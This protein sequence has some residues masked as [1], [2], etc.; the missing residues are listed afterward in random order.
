MSIKNTM[1]IIN[2]LLCLSVIANIVCFLL[3][4]NASEN[5]EKAMLDKEICIALGD[6]LREGSKELTNNARMYAASGDKKYENNYHSILNERTGKIPRFAHRS[7]FP[8]EKYALLDLLNRYGISKDEK[9]LISRAQHLSDAVVPIEIEAF[10]AVKGVFKDRNGEYT[11]KKMPDREK[12]IELVFGQ[13][14]EELIQPI[15]RYMASFDKELHRRLDNVVQQAQE[16]QQLYRMIFL[17]STVLMILIIFFS[18]YYT[19]HTII[20]PLRHT[21]DFAAQIA[22]GQFE[23]RITVKSRNEIGQLVTALNT[24]ADQITKFIAEVRMESESAKEHSQNAKKALEQ[25]ETATSEAQTRTR[26]MLGV[27][28]RLDHAGDVISSATSQLSS[29]LD[30]SDHGA[31]ETAERLSLAAE[32]IND[33]NVTVR[34]IARSANAASR[35]SVETRDKAQ[36]GAAI[37]ER[38][39]KSIANVSEISTQLNTDMLRLNEHAKSISQILGVILDIADQTNL[40]ALNAAIEAARAGESG[41]G[42]AVVADEVRKLA[43]KTTASTADVRKAIEAIQESTQKSMAGVGNAVEHI[44]QATELAEQSG[45]AL[46]TIVATVDTA[47]DQIQSIA[48]ASEQ[49]SARSED[50]KNSINQVNDMAGETAAEMHEAA[51]IV[52]D[53]AQQAHEL[54]EMID[55][56]K[57]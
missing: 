51:R 4:S 18:I 38:S 15:M 6:E 23:N 17:G 26:T 54:T 36:M 47:A 8:G 29:R 19:C 41:R 25:A 22:N 39:L 57:H 37:V 13:K 20:N 50:I 53:L 7:Y 45:D 49:Q 43:E 1:F 28:D 44:R 46:K 2:V 24:M 10:N 21:R 11:I 31:Q 48:A 52:A 9:N 34:E 40:L 35:A 42:F 56:L 27:A 5:I 12:A 16:R 30:H 14:Y 32:A 55:D 3:F 33:L